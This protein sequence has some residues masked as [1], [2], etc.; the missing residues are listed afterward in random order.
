MNPTSRT[1]RFTLVAVFLAAS[2]FGSAVP[3]TTKVVVRADTRLT[4]QAFESVGAIR[5]QD[6]DAFRVYRVPSAALAK[7]QAAAVNL[8]EP[9]EVHDEWDT[10]IFRDRSIDTRLAT[11]VR[12]AVNDPKATDE[13]QIYV[14]QFS[15][16]LT[17]ADEQLL[18]GAG[19]RYLGYIPNNAVL[20]A[21]H[22]RALVRATANAPR[23]EWV[24]VYDR[25]LKPSFPG[26]PFAGDQFVVQ[27]ANT[28]ETL[29]HI[30]E[31]LSKHEV[32][33]VSSY[34]QY[35][36][37]RVRLS[38]SEAAAAMD[39]PL[40]VVVEPGGRDFASGER[41]AV[42]VTT[43]FFTSTVYQSVV[44]SQW[45]PFRLGTSDYRSWLP[46]SVLAAATNYRVA[47]ADSGIDSG[48]CGGVRHPDLMNVMSYQDY[49]NFGECGQDKLGHG[50][51]VAGLAL[52][53]PTTAATDAAGT[54]GTFNY[55]M[56]VAPGAKIFNQRIMTAQGTL[57]NTSGG[58]LTWANDA[59]NNGCVVQNHSHNEYFP[60]A[61]NDG[62]YNT[63]AQA[64]DQAVR[65][66][67]TGDGI[68]TPMAI[69]VSAGNI[70]GGSVDY[71]QGDCSS[72]VLSPATA[73]NVISVG[74]AESYRPGMPTT[75]TGTGVVRQPGDF[76][77]DSFDNVAYISRRATLDNRIKPD[78]IAPATMVS[79]TRSQ[80]P[81]SPFCF[82][83]STQMYY[84]DTGTSF[85]APQ[86]TGAAALLDAKFNMTYS[87]AMLKAA[88]IGTAKSVK[89]GLDRY[90]NTTVPAR[91]NYDQGWGRLFLDDI[92]QGTT[93]YRMLDETS[94]TPFTA[95]LQARSGTFTVADAS[96]PVVI[97]LAWTDEPASVPAG[98]T[99][100]RNLDLEVHSGCTLYSGNYMN[101]SEVSIAQDSCSFGGVAR[102]S[103]NNV[104]MIVVPASALTSMT[105]YVSVR[106]WGF[107][108][109]NQKF[110]L[111]ASNVF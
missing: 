48:P 26:T 52:A 75:C 86:I 93:V 72:R 77:A 16:P 22:G 71:T 108:T 66:T 37:V 2:A 76:L 104:E 4:D 7:L 38:L 5:I 50:T 20:V 19:A 68:D 78:I 31:F 90:T 43:P 24:S 81:S 110:A 21:A 45:Q 41:E 102:D 69:V 67:Y 83:D 95:A 36:N 25:S 70:C 92:I 56:G 109:H 6:Y 40:V 11:D 89:G 99:L 88:L 85:A 73:K 100:A 35:T 65:D 29:S 39:D 106:S 74:A 55:A 47:I 1:L 33:Q 82:T 30:Q 63:T 60:G 84:I 32:L 80:Y 87:P 54:N 3:G 10:V 59:Y 23:V 42:G 34:L 46:S 49:V 9:I 28:P 18:T 53:N 13:L 94:F 91:P 51:M 79:S 105:Y 58:I 103:T 97:V 101:A 57:A 15:S 62:V 14:M 96:K 107:G 8:S 64:Y 98:T 61:G 12:K 111:F 44:G 27:F 17:A